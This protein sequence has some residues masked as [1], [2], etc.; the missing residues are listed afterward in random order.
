MDEK[1]QRVSNVSNHLVDV[2]EH[3]VFHLVIRSIEEKKIIQG[4]SFKK[5][6]RKK[7]HCGIIGSSLL[8]QKH[9]PHLNNRHTYNGMQILQGRTSQQAL[10]V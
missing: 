6:R 3:Y 9:S 1:S 2:G 10:K 7:D 4:G 8:G 5:Y